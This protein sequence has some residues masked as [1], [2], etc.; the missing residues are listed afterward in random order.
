MM[1][2]AAGIGAFIDGFVGWLVFVITSATCPR[3]SAW[4][5]IWCLGLVW[6]R[7]EI[8]VNSSKLH[9]WKR[10]GKKAEP[11]QMTNN[12]CKT[13]SRSCQQKKM[14][15]GCLVFLTPFPQIELI[16]FNFDV[17]I[18]TWKSL[19]FQCKKWLQ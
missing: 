7:F 4:N 18:Q 19:P 15:S 16:L 11:K 9:I 14:Y 13:S 6:Q 17:W 12:L 8:W 2:A 3:L 1:Y 5:N 10:V